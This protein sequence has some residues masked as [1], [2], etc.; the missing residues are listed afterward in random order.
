M[1]KFTHLLKP[2]FVALFLCI[3]IQVNSQPLGAQ[4]RSF[5]IREGLSGGFDFGLAA[6]GNHFSPSLVYYELTPVTKSK[7]IF[8]GWTA[9]VSAFYGNDLNYYTAPARLTRVEN[10]DTVRFGRLSQTSLNLGIRGEWNLGR[11]QLG[12]SVDLLGFT[13]LGRSRIGRVYSSTGLFS[14]TDSLGQDVQ[15][16][17]Q[18]PDAFQAASPTRLNVKLLGA[19]DRGMLTTEVYARMYF[20]PSIALKVGY[21]WLTTEMALNN[22]DQVANNDRFRHRAGLPY[23]ALTLPLNPW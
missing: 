10:I 14:Q 21:Q 12:A 16:S 4:Q 6:K 13:F 18:G 15:K 19:H 20:G 8:L 22:R 23:V 2:I 17:F 9:R 11:L 3:V 1:P 7:T 5:A